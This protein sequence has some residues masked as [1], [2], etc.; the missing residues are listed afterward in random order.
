MWLI[1]E[2]V[3]SLF[4]RAAQC[5]VPDEMY[6]AGVCFWETDGVFSFAPWLFQYS[7]STQWKAF[8]DQ[9]DKINGSLSGVA[10]QLREFP[11]SAFYAM[12]RTEKNRL[13]QRRCRQQKLE[14]PKAARGGR[15]KAKRKQSDAAAAM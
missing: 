7:Q 12:C 8:A 6:K 2:N 9:Y 15:R 4:S 5:V 1:D 11:R 14:K 13:Y 3:D 10:P